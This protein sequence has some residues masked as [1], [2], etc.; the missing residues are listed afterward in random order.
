MCSKTVQPIKTASQDIHRVHEP[1]AISLVVVIIVNPLPGGEAASSDLKVKT[2]CFADLRID[3]LQNEGT[4]AWIPFFA[5]V[6]T[7]A[8]RVATLLPS[9]NWHDC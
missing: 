9:Q 8:S 3:D 1:V 5:R 2:A 6:S 7:L 4:T